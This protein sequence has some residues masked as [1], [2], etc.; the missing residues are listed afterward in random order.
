MSRTPLV[1]ATP[2]FVESLSNAMYWPFVLIAGCWLSKFP[3]TPS[4]TSPPGTVRASTIAI[5]RPSLVRSRT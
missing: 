2:R 4:G 3:I 5:A 1:S